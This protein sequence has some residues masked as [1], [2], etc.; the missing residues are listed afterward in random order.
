MAP[1]SKHNSIS[2]T[3]V[4]MNA[5]LIF[6]SEGNLRMTRDA[7]KLGAKERA[8][9]I[10]LQI[11][12]SVFKTPTLKGVIKVDDPANSQMIVEVAHNASEVLKT[13]GL[14]LNLNVVSK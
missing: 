9:Q 3:T 2:A 5:W 1:Y 6:T 13:A 7:P 14:D 11:P 4:Q 12:L 8:M 10:T